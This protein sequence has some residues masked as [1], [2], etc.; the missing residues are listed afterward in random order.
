MVVKAYPSGLGVQAL[1]NRFFLFVLLVAISLASLT[2]VGIANDRLSHY[3]Y[4]DTKNLVSMVEDAAALIERDGDKAFERFGQANSRWLNQDNYLFV[5]A[6][7]GTCIFHPVTPELIGKN[8][9]SLRDVNGKP[10][11]AQITDI[12]RRPESDASGW[13]FYLWQEQVQLTPNWKSA[14][15]RKVTTP[16]GQTY[17]VGSGS[18]NIKVE[19]PFVEQKVRIAAELLRSAGKSEAFKQFR[20]PAS[21]FIFLDS[22]IFV[23]DEQGRTRRWPDVISRSSRT[24]SASTPFASCSGSSRKRTRPGCSTCGASRAAPRRRES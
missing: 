18:Y 23:L 19:R 24:S 4:S 11:I 3:A 22:F 15:I 14:Y 5:Y 13:V 20:D 9:M 6:L 10:I 7:D 17:V 12:G 16:S 8:L 2:A 21:P 1:A